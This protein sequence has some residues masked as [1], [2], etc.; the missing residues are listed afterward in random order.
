MEMK[1]WCVVVDEV[2]PL[3]VTMKPNDIC[4]YDLKKAIKRE[5]PH[6]I[7]CDAAQLILYLALKDNEWITDDLSGLNE[8]TSNAKNIMNT[9]ESL[10][11]YFNFKE[12]GTYPQCGQFKTTHILVVR[13]TT[14]QATVVPASVPN[15]YQNQAIVPADAPNPIQNQA[16]APGMVPVDTLVEVRHPIFLPV[17]IKAEIYELPNWPVN[18]VIDLPSLYSFMQDYGG[19]TMNGKLYW[20]LEVKQVVSILIDGWFRKS[21]PNNFN[22]NANRKA[23]LLGSPGVGKS[24]LLCIIAFYLA[25]MRNK[26]IIFYRRVF[27]VKQGNCLL[28]FI[29][30]NDQVVFQ[31]IRNC[32]TSR[33]IEFYGIH[34]RQHGMKNVWLFLDGIIYNT[35]PEGLLTFMLLATSQQVY[36]KPQAEVDA[37]GCLLPC[38]SKE[39]LISMGESVHGYTRE[40]MEERFYYSGG[41]ARLF[42]YPMIKLIKDSITSAVK[43]VDDP[44]VTYNQKTVT[45]ISDTQVDRLR[46]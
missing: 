17:S 10:S 11:H 27:K 7:T 14:T 36:L 4:M 44:K 42:T 41:I 43:L 9:Y 2:I 45:S 38:W 39:N 19:C 20:R 3:Y 12:K 40:Q 31:A 25:L 1:L 24:T 29:P 30:N 13:P 21:T 5:L 35:I 33:A 22:V 16:I 28:C 6:V 8:V 18:S 34:T 26:I 46:H 37:Y 23:C 32:S 15:A